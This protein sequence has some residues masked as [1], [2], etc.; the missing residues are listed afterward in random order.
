[1][2]EINEQNYERLGKVPEL[3]R[4]INGGAMS[5]AAC[6][7][8]EL[9]IA[10]LLAEGPKRADELARATA[11]HEPSMHRFLRALAALEV[12][13]ER[14]DGAFALAPMGMLLRSDVPNSLRSWA[15]WCG[16]HMWPVSGDLIHSVKT[17]ETARQ[18]LGSV[19]R[20]G[21]L[22]SDQA[23]ATVFNNAM[24][25]LSRLVA[26]EVLL[27][28]EFGAMQRVVDVGGG[29]GALLAAVLTAHPGVRGV[30]FDLP[31]AIE[32]ARTHLS[33]AGLTDRCELIA[34][35]FFESVPNGADAYLLKAVLHD[36]D[37]QKSQAI[38]LNC[39]RAIPLNGKLLLI[40][41]IVP[42]RFE[43]C[44]LHHAIAWADLTMLVEFGGRERTVREFRDLLES[45]GF[46]LTSATATSLGYSVLEGIPC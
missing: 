21:L 23:A 46:K 25:E 30:L 45:S 32:G 29:Y 26:S 5:Q 20:F 35:D 42:D 2:T 11:C 24:A 17:G 9:G 14:D 18:R 36:W 6:V 10:D 31:Q 37:D 41:R 43:A 3:I 7:T 33:N 15:I 12:C 28:Y 13:V 1:M 40:E 44:S 39:R 4:L 27:S 8:A 34:G 16:K 22:E 19:D 38:L